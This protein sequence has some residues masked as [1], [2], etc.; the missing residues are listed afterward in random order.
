MICLNIRQGLSSELLWIRL[1]ITAEV[2]IYKKELFS[3]KNILYKYKK[4]KSETYNYT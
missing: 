3:E 1:G 2:Y 4:S